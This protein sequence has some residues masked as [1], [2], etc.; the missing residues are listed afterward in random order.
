M[1]S[2]SKKQK[3][4]SELVATAEAMVM[5][6][7]L[8]RDVDASDD[9]EDDCYEILDTLVM[10]YDAISEPPYN[11]YQNMRPWKA[12]EIEKFVTW[13]EANRDFLRGAYVK[14]LTK[15]K[16]EAFPDSEGYKHLSAQKVKDKYYNMKKAYKAAKAIQAKFGIGKR[17]EDCERSVN[18]IG[19]LFTFFL[20]LIG[21]YFYFY[22]YCYFYFYYSYYHRDYFVWGK[23]FADLRASSETGEE[24]HAFLEVGC[25]LGTLSYP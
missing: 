22:F 6:M 17:E 25:G 18:G 4:Q 14:W 10:A 5:S 16:A 20:I 12:E 13:M 2:L 11:R 1:P 21:G 19:F 23:V 8:N 3:I 9:E 7:L 15:V 24:V